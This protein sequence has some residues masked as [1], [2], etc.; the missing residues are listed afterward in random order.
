MLSRKAF[1]VDNHMGN[2]SRPYGKPHL[3]YDQQ[4]SCSL[5]RLSQVDLQRREMYLTRSVGFGHCR[6]SIAHVPSLS[7]VAQFR[8]Y[9]TFRGWV[10]MNENLFRHPSLYLLA[11]ITTAHLCPQNDP[12]A[13]LHDGDVLPTLRRGGAMA[14]PPHPQEPCIFCVSLIV[15]GFEVSSH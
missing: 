12:P 6:V 10:K 3:T 8:S 13:S 1:H 9:C 4:V 5:G 2:I 7:V 11:Q 14:A 15:C